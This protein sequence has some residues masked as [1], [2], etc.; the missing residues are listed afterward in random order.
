[1]GTE[2]TRRPYANGTGEAPGEAVFLPGTRRS[3]PAEQGAGVGP[4]PR[5]NDFLVL[6]SCLPPAT[7]ERNS[8]CPERLGTVCSPARTEVRLIVR[9]KRHREG[10]DPPGVTLQGG[11]HVEISGNLPS[12]HVA[13]DETEQE[14]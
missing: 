9:H 3:A 7:R 5:G 11:I 4:A 12:S 14:G 2:H 8:V 13:E 6:R 1:M 10:A